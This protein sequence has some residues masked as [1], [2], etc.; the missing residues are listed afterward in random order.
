MSAVAEAVLWEEQT[1]PRRERRPCALPRSGG[2]T[3]GQ[4]LARAREAGQSGAAA[5]CPVCGGHLVVHG[6]EDRCDDCGSRL[7]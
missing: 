7:S 5:A 4:L 3:L 6:L 2:L 1:E